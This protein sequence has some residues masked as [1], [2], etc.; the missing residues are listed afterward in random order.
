MTI[1]LNRDTKMYVVSEFVQEHNHQLHHSST[2]HMIRS[3]RKMSVAQEIE[4]DIAYDSGIRLKDAYQFF[5][6][7]VGG[8]DG[9][10]YISRDQKNYLRTKRQRSLLYG[11]ASSL[12]R[13]FS[14]KLKDNPS[15]YYAIQLD[16]EEHITNIFWADARMIIDY[17][18]FG[19]V[20]TFD[21]TY[22]TNRA[23][24]PLGVFLG[25]NHH[26]ETVVFGAS[27]L[28]DETIESFI[29]LFETFLEAM[30]AKKP[31]TIF[32][33]ADVAM[34]TAIK[35]VMPDTY[36]ALCSW[37]MW[38]NALK[39]LGYL[40]KGESRFSTDFSACIYQY[41][42]EGTFLQAWIELLDNYNLHENTWL[43]DL[44]KL[45][46]KWSQ[47]YVKKT[48]TAGMRTTQ[49]SER[50]NC[51]LKDCLKTNT[52]I[53][54]FFTHFERVV[55]QKRYKEL[56]AEYDS[57]Q[58]MPRLTLTTS[59][60][61]NQMSKVYTPKIF[62][63]FQ[64]E[65]IGV[66]SLIITSRT[67]EQEKHEYVVGVFNACKECTVSFNPFNGSIACSCKMFETCGI[68]CRH[69]I[70]VFD[71]LD[72]KIIPNNYIIRRW[73]RNARDDELPDFHENS[74][75]EYSERYR[76]LCPIF[77]QLVNEACETEKG[78]MI[79][80]SAVYDLRKKIREARE[81]DNITEETTLISTKNLSSIDEP[82]LTYT[83]RGI[84]KKQNTRCK[85]RRPKTWI[86]RMKKPRGDAKQAF[87]NASSIESQSLGDDVI[88]SR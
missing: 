86:E 76:S 60:M 2:V 88:R 47:A 21:T 57:R 29:W 14:K 5:S 65:V 79:L 9:L 33:D 8:C 34:S 3:Q 59:P 20:L 1:I 4:T 48:F 58:K 23:A 63:V 67:I 22:G 44:F 75:L 82:S 64:N 69:G 52:N 62:E 25:L 74:K 83:A 81:P 68:L 78:Y 36:H 35:E 6:S 84:K 17:N 38:Q 18:I 54:E 46:E 70:K 51:D 39:H 16:T 13:Y 7:Q 49:L 66:L 27:L 32:T 73:T 40:L 87:E 56:E 45:K 11:E 24:R 26:R 10:G 19:D 80:S 28:Y 37:H 31:R 71:T 42:D 77:V 30:N 53:V 72:I 50:F 61:L 12:E 85:K 15:Y 41:D 43:R 55:E